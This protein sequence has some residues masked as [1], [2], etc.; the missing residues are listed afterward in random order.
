M[1]IFIISLMVTRQCGQMGTL[2][3]TGKSYT[4]LLQLI[5]LVPL[6]S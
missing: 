3:L 1:Y 4:M 6:V 5:T 2:Q